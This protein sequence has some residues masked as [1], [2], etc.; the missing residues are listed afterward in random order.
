MDF[1]MVMN[2]SRGLND[3]ILVP[4]IIEDVMLLEEHGILISILYKA[5]RAMSWIQVGNSIKAIVYIKMQ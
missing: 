1:S 3:N 4:R 5:I 2:F